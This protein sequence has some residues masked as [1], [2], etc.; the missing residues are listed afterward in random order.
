M[1]CKGLTE[2]ERK[3]AEQKSELISA[4]LCS[5]GYNY[6]ECYG[7]AAIGFI[8]AVKFCFQF[9]S[10]TD[11]QFTE[12]ADLFMQEAMTETLS[13]LEIVNLDDVTE[14]FYF[15]EEEVISEQTIKTAAENF[16]KVKL[17]EH[18]L[19]T[20]DPT[21]KRIMEMIYAGVPNDQ[22]LNKQDISQ[23]IF[24]SVLT[25]LRSRISYAA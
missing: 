24:D 5:H 18:L 19:R 17:V 13:P 8:R 4:F 3:F 14:E 16:M 25:N 21:E 10:F 9:S 2:R 20:A 23:E 1:K 7:D 12:I 11:E 15:I 6:E 22:I